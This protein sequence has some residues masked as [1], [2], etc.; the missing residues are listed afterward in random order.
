MSIIRQL[1][2][3]QDV[4]E[5]L[6]ADKNYRAVAVHNPDLIVGLELEIERWPTPPEDCRH[7]GFTF[8]SDGSLRNSGVEAITK[9]TK[10]KNIPNLLKSFF[11]HFEV[12]EDNYSDR[13]SIHVH[14]N[15]QDLS[16]EQVRTI[17]LLYQAVERILFNFVDDSRRGNIFCVP[18]CE[19][20][21][22]DRFV[23]RFL[24]D[25]VST[26]R[27]WQKY[28]A[29][30]LLPLRELGTIEFRHLEGTC[31]LGKIITW[32]DIISHIFSYATSVDY[33]ELKTTILKM[34]TV[35]NYGEF[36]NT[37]FGDVAPVLQSTEDF[38]NCLALGIIDCKLALTENKKS[39]K[40]VTT[41]PQGTVEFEPLQG[42]LDTLIAGMNRGHPPNP[43]SYRS[44]LQNS[45]ISVDDLFDEVPQ[46]EP[47]H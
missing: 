28:S 27:I 5:R 18:W 42:R 19:S 21:V 7:R 16:V 2:G 39:S 14:V 10:L 38:S 46:Q 43:V 35:S 36:I 23:P 25:P 32:L 37:V 33:Q 45:I 8:T 4:N 31:D 22:A 20:G 1:Y 12:T 29:L 26:I 40:K 6:S 30:N 17:C 34:N 15:C 47:F 11:T 9:P 24:D 41:V 13:C 3:L 44:I